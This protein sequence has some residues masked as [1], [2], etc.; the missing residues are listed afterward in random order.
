MSALPL[1]F[2]IDWETSFEAGEQEWRAEEDSG[3]EGDHQVAERYHDRAEPSG[4]L[5]PEAEE[6]QGE[7]DQG[8][9]EEDKGV[10]LTG[11]DGKGQGPR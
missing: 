6:H 7:D 2:R 10:G 4:L 5:R 8:A 11:I 9:D 1:V 3:D